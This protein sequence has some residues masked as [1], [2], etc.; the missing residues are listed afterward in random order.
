[1]SDYRR[2]YVKGGVFFFTVATYERRP[3]FKT[4]SAVSALRDSFKRAIALY[5]FKVDSMVVLPDHL[6]AIW[7]L[8]EDDSDFSVRWRLIK[9]IFTRGKPVTLPKPASD[10]RRMKKERAI[11]QRRFWEHMIRDEADLNRHRDYIHYNPVKHGLATSP[12]QWKHSSFHRFVR[13]GLYPSDWGKSPQ[14]QVL[15]MD[16]E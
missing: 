8:P 2:A 14:K 9:T 10:S 6:H 16:L 7:V 3:L 4:E 1:M 15:E 11:W 13:Q 5:P 12:D